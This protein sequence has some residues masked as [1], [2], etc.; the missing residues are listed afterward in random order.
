MRHFLIAQF[1]H[2]LLDIS[3]RRDQFFA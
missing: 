2:C 1:D 3:L